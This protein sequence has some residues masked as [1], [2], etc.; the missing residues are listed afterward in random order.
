MRHCDALSMLANVLTK[1]LQGHLFGKF[2]D[3][4]LG[5]EPL[6]TLDRGP[7]TSLERVDKNYEKLKEVALRHPGKKTFT[8]PDQILSRRRRLRDCQ[9]LKRS[10]HIVDSKPIL[11]LVIR[12]ASTPPRG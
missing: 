10:W 6:S 1:P 4:I 3:V 9:S 11:V 8:D 5:Y 12:L 2:C 7:A